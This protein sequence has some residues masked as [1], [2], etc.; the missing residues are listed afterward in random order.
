MPYF[1]EVNAME[2]LSRA[3]KMLQL[4]QCAADDGLT[5]D[6]SQDLF[7]DPPQEERTINEDL[8]ADSQDFFP[9]PPRKVQTFNADLRS[10]LGTR[11][12][13]MFSSSSSSSSGDSCSS[14]SSSCDSCSS[15]SEDVDDDIKDRDYNVECDREYL[16]D[17][18]IE[19][20]PEARL[21]Q[22]KLTKTAV[23]NESVYPVEAEPTDKG[24]KRKKNQ[25]GWKRN[26]TKTLRNSGQE[27][28]SS[29]TQRISRN[30]KS[31]CATTCRYV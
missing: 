31:P 3:K 23:A 21:A 6:L 7:P 5:A 19:E 26:V 30:I 12:P 13:D 10:I 15:S 24:Y 18:I 4:A 9:E 20:N 22:A 16:S 14:S 25:Q 2:P 27:Y 28:A 8:T 1:S 11:K 29:T 17:N